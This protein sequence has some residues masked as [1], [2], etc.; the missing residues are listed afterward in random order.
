MNYLILR[1]RI[2]IV[3]HDTPENTH[4]ISLSETHFQKHASE[5]DSS[6]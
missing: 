5:D 2:S 3:V 4:V 1:E 6:D